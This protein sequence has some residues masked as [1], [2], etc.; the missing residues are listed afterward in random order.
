MS[1]QTMACVT[2]AEGTFNDHRYR[3][4]GPELVGLVFRGV[5]QRLPHLVASGI[6]AMTA[7]EVSI[8]VWVIPSLIVV[9]GAMV[10]VVMQG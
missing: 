8:L 9:L 6:G 1:R 2:G 7:A 10:A 3:D 5:R 4:Y